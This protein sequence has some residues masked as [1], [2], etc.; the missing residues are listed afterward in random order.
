MKK[1]KERLKNQKGFTLIEMLI[2]VAIIAILVAVS[3]PVVNDSMDKT[4][5]AT[6]AANER[7][8][9]AEIMLQYLA[10]T[11]ATIYTSGNPSSTTT[12]INAG[13][14]YYYD[15]ARG[16]ISTDKTSITE[17]GKCA[18]AAT[19][20]EDKILALKINED[21]IVSMQ[22]GAEAENDIKDEN[23]CTT[24]KDAKHTT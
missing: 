16:V 15:A 24:A 10:G 17:Y 9:K 21:G 13:D 8:A 2:V 11:D 3:I 18:K 4:K 20:H 14:V 19:S 6:D 1:F 22:W 23:L 12:K 7:A 5:H